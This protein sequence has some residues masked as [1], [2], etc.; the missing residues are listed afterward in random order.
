MDE[1]LFQ[2]MSYRNIGPFS[3]GRVAT[4]TGVPNDTYTFYMGATGGGVW[5]TP[6]A[7][8]AWSSVSDVLFNTCRNGENVGVKDNVLRWEADFV[9]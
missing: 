9:D 2:S 1:A 4:V 3:G 5:R 7:G 8:T 6:D